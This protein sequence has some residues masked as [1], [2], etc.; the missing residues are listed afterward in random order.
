[1]QLLQRVNS[2]VEGGG[3]ESRDMAA[4]LRFV[5]SD[6][7]ELQSFLEAMLAR[8]EVECTAT[9]CNTLQHTATHCNTLQHTATHY[10]TL[11]RSATHCNTLQHTLDT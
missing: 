2:H 9:H 7:R 10:D 11:Q 5:G 8:G 6:E 1:M 3:G 4:L